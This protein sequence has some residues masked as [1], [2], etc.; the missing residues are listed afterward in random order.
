MWYVEHCVRICAMLSGL[1]VD[2]I[3]SQREGKCATTNLTIGEE[4]V[5]DH[6]NTRFQIFQS[7]KG[8]CNHI[9]IDLLSKIVHFASCTKEILAEKYA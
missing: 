9:F 4:M 1:S 6:N 8:N 2:E 5:V 3:K 7:L